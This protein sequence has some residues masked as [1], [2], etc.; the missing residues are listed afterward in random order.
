MYSLAYNNNHTTT[1]AVIII[2]FTTSITLISRLYFYNNTALCEFK[3]NN[4]RTHARYIAFR[5][6]V[7]S[8]T[9]AFI[10]T[11]NVVFYHFLYY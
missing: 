1:I 10:V 3:K 4:K 9:F 6:S 7:F 11:I 5:W 8:M 2:A